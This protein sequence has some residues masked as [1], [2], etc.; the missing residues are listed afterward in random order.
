MKTP[1]V[2]LFLIAFST[3]ALAG[4]DKVDDAKETIK[5]DAREVGQTI[6][7]DSKQVG[8]A[9]ARDS[10]AVGHAVADKSKQVGHA[11]AQDSREAAH[12]ATAGTGLSTSRLASNWNRRGS[13]AAAVKTPAP[14]ASHAPLPKVK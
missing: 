13:T 2:A 9:V 8:K 1:Y 14:S 7:R 11:V 5:Q 6:A 4:G 3:V 12:T 10:K